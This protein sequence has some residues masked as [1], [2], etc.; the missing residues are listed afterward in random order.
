M[1]EHA[2]SSILRFLTDLFLKPWVAMIAW[3]AFVH[4]TAAKL[5]FSLPSF[6]YWEFFMLNAVCGILTASQIDRWE[7]AK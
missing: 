1:K 4:M 5:P 3:G 7:K 6:G 2:G